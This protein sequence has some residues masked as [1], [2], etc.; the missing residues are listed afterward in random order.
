[1]FKTSFASV[2]ALGLLVLGGCVSQTKPAPPVA[3]APEGDQCG[4]S[5]VADFVGKSPTEQT[6]AAIRERAKPQTIRVIRPNSPVTMDYRP[7]RL[8]I[9]LGE[10][11]LIKR[12][13]CV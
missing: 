6:I 10:D 9:D 8:N 7:D 13:H 1:M 3:T 4:A 12:F 5:K 2:A 11:G